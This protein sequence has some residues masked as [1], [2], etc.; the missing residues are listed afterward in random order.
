[1]RK[2]KITLRNIHYLHTVGKFE[3]GVINIA[4][5]EILY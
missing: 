2:G 1:M 5:T 4:E 3:Y